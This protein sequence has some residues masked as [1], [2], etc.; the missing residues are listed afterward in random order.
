MTTTDWLLIAVF[1]LGS[2]TLVGIF[3]TKTAGFGRYTTSAIL[4]SL[5]TI[6]SALLVAAGTI[7]TSIFVNIVFA[8]TGFAGGLVTGKDQ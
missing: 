3:K 2:G 1:L 8:I 4:L 5:V 7:D 6:V